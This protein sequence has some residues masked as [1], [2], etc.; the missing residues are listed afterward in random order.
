M[1]SSSTT[2]TSFDARPFDESLVEILSEAARE[3]AVNHAYG[4]ADAVR[5]AATAEA[6][7]MITLARAKAQSVSEVAEA[8]QRGYGEE[9]ARL[10]LASEYVDAFGQLGGRSSTIVVPA[11]A[12]NVAS[13]L[14]QALTAYDGMKSMQRG[15]DGAK[16]ARK[17]A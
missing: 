6:E 5:A 4:D 7:K 15:G 17:S 12:A 2:A 9:A 11:D 10:A 3:S 8:L 13:V 14:G 1:T 16:L